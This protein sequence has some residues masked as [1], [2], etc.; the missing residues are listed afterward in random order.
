MRMVDIGSSGSYPTRIVA[1]STD[2]LIPVIL[3]AAS[4]TRADAGAVSV[5]T[6][7]T[8][9]TTSG[10]AAITLADGTYH[11]Q[12][13]KIQMTVDVGDATL[14]IASPV[15]AALDTVTFADVGDY[16]L[17]IWNETQGYWRIL[18]AGNDADGVSA[19]VVA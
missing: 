19:P 1:G 9:V 18:A 6:Y 16:V 13:K 8:A 7:Y 14:T 3:D 4:D 10:A 17:L 15:S 5:T 12:L 2:L 11:G